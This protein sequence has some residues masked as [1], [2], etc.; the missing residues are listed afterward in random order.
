M[1]MYFQCGVIHPLTAQGK[2]VWKGIE[3]YGRSMDIIKECENF[4]SRPLLLNKPLIRPIYDDAD[5]L[6]WTSAAS[7]LPQVYM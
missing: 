7:R 5:F 6:F 3:G 4:S 2:E 1:P